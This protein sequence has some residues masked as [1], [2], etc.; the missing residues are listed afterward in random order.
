MET[1]KNT[2][3]YYADLHNHCNISYGHGSLH[4][5]LRNGRQRLDICSVTGHA[6][7]PDMPSRDGKIDHIIDFHEKGFSKLKTGWPEVLRIMQEHNSAA[8]YLVYP[9]FEI[10]SMDAGDYTLLSKNFNANII[11][12]DSIDQLRDLLIHQPELRSR[13]LPFPHHIGYTQGRRGINWDKFCSEVFP[14]VE[15]YSMH[16]CAETDENDHPFL[17]TMGPGS[18]AG[19]MRYGLGPGE[20]WFGV[21]GNTDH[22]SAHPGSYGHGFSGIW[23]ESLDRDAVW[24]ALW[25][26]RTFALTAD[27]MKLKFAVNE[28]AMGSQASLRDKQRI[29][30]ELQ[31]GGVLDYVDIIKNG[32]LFSRFSQ[33][34]FAPSERTQQTVHTLLYL[35]LG[36]GERNKAFA[37]DV[38]FGIDKGS[39]Q[40]VDARFRGGEVVS[41]LDSPGGSEG[42]FNSS[43][44]REGRHA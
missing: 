27:K 35:E 33:L 38:Q 16:G 4:D 5:A 29:E 40:S 39:I 13:Y 24:D 37:W 14:L 34:D 10:H 15:I 9:G 2:H 42:D 8:E 26:R 11:Y 18:G 20:A 44:T 1:Y 43:W 28:T 6:H 25:Q 17:H 41:P 7:W 3:V 19:T 12:P 31:A 30:F 32:A 36:W 22:H 23:A 21:L